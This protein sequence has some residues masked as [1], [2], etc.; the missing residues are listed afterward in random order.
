MPERGPNLPECMPTLEGRARRSED[1]APR[2]EVP[3]S[4]APLRSALPPSHP[5]TAVAPLSLQPC[6]GGPPALAF[7]PSPRPSTVVPAF[8]D[9][10][11]TS[12]SSPL[13]AAV[14]P[15]LAPRAFPSAPPSSLLSQAPPPQPPL[16]LLSLPRC[17][18]RSPLPLAAEQRRCAPMHA[19]GRTTRS[20]MTADRETSI[21]TRSRVLSAPWE[22]TAMTV[23]RGSSAPM[24]SSSE[25]RVPKAQHAL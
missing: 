20:V 6:R 18:R 13:A 23:A 8:A 7:P 10:R 14:P 24:H 2:E 21:G 19:I 11:P 22:A 9:P 3:P 25:Q 4:A 15:S 5:H 16:S 12:C 17:S 1:G